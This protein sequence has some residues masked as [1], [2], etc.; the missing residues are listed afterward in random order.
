MGPQNILV[1][2]LGALG[3]FIQSL[4]PMRAI[5]QA[6]PDAKITL[7][8]TSPFENFAEKSGYFDSIV[9]DKRPKWYHYK[10]WRHLKEFLNV[11]KI[12]WLKNGTD[13]GTDGHVDN[14][15]CFVNP[16]TV[17]ALACKDKKD[18]FY[19]KTIRYTT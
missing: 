17:L 16:G 13:E 5:R 15:A 12:I 7:L 4:G 1:I 18:S 6:H 11:S 14:V 3:D 9:L 10:E 8:T 19:E 2:K